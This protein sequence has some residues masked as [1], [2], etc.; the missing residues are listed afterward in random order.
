MCTTAVHHP[1]TVA[2]LGHPRPDADRP[3]GGDEGARLLAGRGAAGDARRTRNAEAVEPLGG[4]ISLTA[5]AGTTRSLGVTYPTEVR[6][7][8]ERAGRAARRSGRTQGSDC[9]TV[10]SSA[11]KPPS[12]TPTSIANLRPWWESRWRRVRPHCR[13]ARARMAAARTRSWRPS[14][15]TSR[16]ACCCRVHFESYIGPESPNDVSTTPGEGVIRLSPV[17]Y[18]SSR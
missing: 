5:A 16:R 4:F 2:A 17:R 9:G 10:P 1:G 13:S 7:V 3:Q 15:A 18:S 14:R 8:I 11:H 6:S 12:S